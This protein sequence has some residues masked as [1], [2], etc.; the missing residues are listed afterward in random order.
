M[1]R[2]N[3]DRTIAS[4]PVAKI[5]VGERSRSLRE[6]AVVALIESIKTIGLQTPISLQIDSSSR[7]ERYVLVAGLHR[8]EA[9]RRL[10]MA[11]VDARIVDLDETERRLELSP[12][13]GDGVKDQ[14]AAWA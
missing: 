3:V 10:G 7:D 6:E 8:L 9:C 5:R 2:D 13:F 4:V 12:N 11:H 14:A 1:N